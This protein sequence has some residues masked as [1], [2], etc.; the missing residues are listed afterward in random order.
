[1]EF[2]SVAAC[3]MENAAPGV[4]NAFKPALAKLYGIKSYNALSAKRL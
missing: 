4:N 2:A 3:Y 1:M